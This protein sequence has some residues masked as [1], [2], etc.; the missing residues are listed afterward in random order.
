VAAEPLREP[1]LGGTPAHH[2]VG[3]DTVHRARGERITSPDRG[4]E[5]GALA[6]VADPGSRDVLVDVDFEV[7]VRR[8]LVPLAA[9]LVQAD[10][11]ALAL[12]VIVVD[13]HA[14]DGADAPG[15]T[16]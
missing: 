3:I 5:E 12:R 6:V 16:S 13:A 4:P 10:P 7:M 9:F 2:A 15:R 8:H 11:P 14:D 1:C